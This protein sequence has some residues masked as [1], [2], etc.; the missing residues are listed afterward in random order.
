MKPSNSKQYYLS[1]K[2]TDIDFSAKTL[3]HQ[4]YEDC[5]FIECN[6]SKSILDQ[7]KFT[8]CNFKDCNLSLVIIKQSYFYDLCFEDSKLTGINWTEA[9]WSNLK[10]PCLL[11]FSKC[12][13]NYSNFFG[14]YLREAEIIECIAHEVDFREADLS[15]ANLSN[16]DFENSF[17]NNTNLSEADFTDAINYHINIYFNNI[18]KAR[19][20]LPEATNLL[21]S[22]DIIIINS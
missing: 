2:F 4:E 12:L 6:F 9:N 21:Y 15:Q 18:K 16:T 7:C 8:S 13:L 3:S 20:S 19:F 5:S 14:L 17:F 11:K 22:L 1:E 10:L